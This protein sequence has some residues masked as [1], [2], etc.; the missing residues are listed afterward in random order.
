V[1]KRSLPCVRQRW[2][3]LVWWSANAAFY[4]AISCGEDPLPTPTSSLPWL[5][6]SSIA[7]SSASRSGW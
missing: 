2:A 1:V 7:I 6:W 5:S 3:K 4:I